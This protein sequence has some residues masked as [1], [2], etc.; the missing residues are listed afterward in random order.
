[1]TDGGQ[2]FVVRL[3]KDLP[4]HGV[5][6]SNELTAS[7]AAFAAGISPEVVY[8]EAGVVVL[9]YIE[10]LALTAELVRDAALL[11]IGRLTRI[12]VAR[13]EYCSVGPGDRRRDG[14]GGGGE[15]GQRYG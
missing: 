14:C 13:R 9:R 12:F 1:M 3:G 11:G 2:Q 4:V 10:G 5:V 15:R 8:A 6:R 7:R